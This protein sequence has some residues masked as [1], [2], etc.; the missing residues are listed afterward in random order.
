MMTDVN[1][2]D[3][4]ADGR[5]GAGAELVQGMADAAA[6][7]PRRKDIRPLAHLLPFV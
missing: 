5:P 3:I 4:S 7:R 6:R 1:G 2:G